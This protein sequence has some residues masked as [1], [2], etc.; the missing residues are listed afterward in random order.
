MKFNT[1]LLLAAANYHERRGDS[2]ES[3]TSVHT[4]RIRWPNGVQDVPVAD[5]NAFPDDFD[6]EVG[7]NGTFIGPD[8]AKWSTNVLGFVHAPALFYYSNGWFIRRE[9]FCGR[10]GATRP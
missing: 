6:A 4:E 8:G 9:M 3:L 1:S 5:Y 10:I 7:K 2:P